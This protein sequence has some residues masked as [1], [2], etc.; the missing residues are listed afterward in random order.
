MSLDPKT[1]PGSV[2]RVVGLP[3]RS[4]MVT[5]T[6]GRI[7]RNVTVSTRREVIG[8]VDYEIGVGSVRIHIELIP[9]GQPND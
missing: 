3:R 2:Q 4:F 7:T 9:E 6:V 1:Q 8:L 5:S